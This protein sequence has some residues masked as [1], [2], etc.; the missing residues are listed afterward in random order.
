MDRLSWWIFD[1]LR[2][3]TTPQLLDG[4]INELFASQNRCPMSCK[5]GIEIS[6]AIRL[7]NGWGKF[8]FQNVLRLEEDLHEAR[9]KAAPTPHPLNGAFWGI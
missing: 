9:R 8:L 5:W 2:L 6:G 4:L 1:F 3:A 7:R